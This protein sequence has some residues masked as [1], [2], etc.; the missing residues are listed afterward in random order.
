MYVSVCNFVL[1]SSQLTFCIFKA[2]LIG[3]APPKLK[4]KMARMV[5]TKAALSIRVDALTDADGKSDETASSIGIENRAKLESRLRALE[6]E[7]EGT[8]IRRFG[9]GGKKQQRFEMKGETKT[10]NASADQV[11][12]VSTQ[13]EDPMEV[14]LKVVADV[15]EEKRMAKEERRAKK[16]AD[17]AK[18]SDDE[19]E[20]DVDGETKKEKKEKKRK[21][22]E[23]DGVPMDQDEPEQP[24]VSSLLTSVLYEIEHATCRRRQRK[25]KRRRR[26]RRRRPRLLP[27]PL[28]LGRTY[29]RRKRKSLRHSTSPNFSLCFI[30]VHLLYLSVI[31]YI[32]VIKC[33]K[34]HKICM[35]LELEALR[36]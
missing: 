5:A 2:S 16:R 15:K 9:D 20:M 7:I 35:N 11:D 26:R 6:H 12:L 8:G 21:R 10:Y 36:S 1:A 31:L 13:R 19:D 34:N 29:P 17:K 3:Q 4:G 28:P 18:E 25:R 30:T 22:R 23:S 27:P 33:S 14:A 24:K 32:I